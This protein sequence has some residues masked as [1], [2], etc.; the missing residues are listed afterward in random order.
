VDGDRFLED[1]QEEE[2]KNPESIAFPFGPDLIRNRTGC[3]NVLEDSAGIMGFFPHFAF[4]RLKKAG[5]PR[6]L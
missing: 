2:P 6:I 5:L 4:C 1:R 3:W